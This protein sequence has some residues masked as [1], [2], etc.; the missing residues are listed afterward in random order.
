MTVYTGDS[1]AAR[2]ARMWTELGPDA[3]LQLIAV[4]VVVH[5]EA[6]ANDMPGGLEAVLVEIRAM[7]RELQAEGL[8]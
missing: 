2:I 7:A 8:S 4:G 6:E 1:V 3:R 5:L